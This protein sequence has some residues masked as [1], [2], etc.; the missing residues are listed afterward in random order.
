MLGWMA[1]FRVVTSPPFPFLYDGHGLLI[2]CNAL[3]PF[4]EFT[5]LNNS[6]CSPKFSFSMTS[7]NPVVFPIPNSLDV[8]SHPRKA[9][10]KR[11]FPQMFSPSVFRIELTP[12]HLRA[13]SFFGS[14]RK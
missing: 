12:M 4:E 9:C 2:S 14:G 10:T 8:V 7:F 3:V 13:P 11:I 6:A 1:F 5:L